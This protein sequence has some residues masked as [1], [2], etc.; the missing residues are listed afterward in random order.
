MRDRCTSKVIILKLMCIPGKFPRII[1]TAASQSRALDWNRILDISV[2]CSLHA[3]L[4]LLWLLC[5]PPILQNMP[6]KLTE[7]SKLPIDLILSVN[8]VLSV[9]VKWLTDCRPVHILPKVHPWSRT[10]DG[11]LCFLFVVFKGEDTHWFASYFV[12]MFKKILTS[13]FLSNTIVSWIYILYISLSFTYS[14]AFHRSSLPAK[15]I[16]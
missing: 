10:E 4:G 13:L 6:A 2:W 5:F 8:G 9:S 7:D 3:Y 16:L 15:H 14:L 1:S 11:W 12:Y